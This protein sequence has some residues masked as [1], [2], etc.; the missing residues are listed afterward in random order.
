MTKQILMIVEDDLS[1]RKQMKWALAADYEIITVGDR[2][3]ALDAAVKGAQVVTLDLGLPPDAD[4]AGEGLLCLKELLRID[5]YLKVIIIT[6][7]TDKANAHEG[8]S[9][10]AYDYMSKPVD[11]DELRIVLKRAFHV[12]ERYSLLLPRSHR[13]MYRSL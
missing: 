13:P 12:A 10:G 3:E 4:G 5:P 8:I 7:N 2:K 9:N 11:M 6:G 1:I